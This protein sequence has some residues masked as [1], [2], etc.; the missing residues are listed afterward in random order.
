[1]RSTE[2]APPARPGHWACSVAARVVLPG[3]PLH[4]LPRLLAVASSSQASPAASRLAP[5]HATQIPA[6]PPPLPRPQPVRQP[7]P[8]G[9]SLGD[10]ADRVDRRRGARSRSA[11]G[12]RRWRPDCLLLGPAELSSASG[13]QVSGGAWETPGG[14]GSRGANALGEERGVREDVRHRA[15]GAASGAQQKY[16]RG[17]E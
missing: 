9:S 3:K 4:A 16:K 15:S 13:V 5:L 10:R 7:R 6:P 17:H 11:W 1:M 8:P 14:A 2:P 12:R